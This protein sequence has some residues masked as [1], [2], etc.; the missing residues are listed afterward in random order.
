M[1]DAHDIAATA[2]TEI[3]QENADASKLSDNAYDELLG[4]AKVQQEL[5]QIR[6]ELLEQE[7]QAHKMDNWF[8]RGIIALAL[9]GVAL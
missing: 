4:A 8:Y 7:R 1:L 3:A 5:S 2:N 6:Q 9:I